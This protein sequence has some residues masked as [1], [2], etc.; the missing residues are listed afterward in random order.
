MPLGSSI[1]GWIV[2]AVTSRGRESGCGTSGR[3]DVVMARLSWFQASEAPFAFL[4][5]GSAKHLPLQACSLI[6]F[7]ADLLQR[8]TI[9]SL[10]FFQSMRSRSLFINAR[11]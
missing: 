5:F 8:A 10:T 1:A 9:A 2:S 3:R 11:R 6:Q 7:S 4:G